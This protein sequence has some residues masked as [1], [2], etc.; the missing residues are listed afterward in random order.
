MLRNKKIEDAL[1]AKMICYLVRERE[2][3]MLS[4]PRSLVLSTRCD[5]NLTTTT[6][7]RRGVTSWDQFETSHDDFAD[8]QEF[9]YSMH[10]GLLV[11]ET[12][13]PS[14]IA[15]LFFSWQPVGVDLLFFTFAAFG[16]PIAFF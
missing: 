10:T 11:D 1:P 16:N 7:K 6:K 4:F 14:L 2:K 8:L 13:S 3:K 12:I 9:F 5:L 15:F